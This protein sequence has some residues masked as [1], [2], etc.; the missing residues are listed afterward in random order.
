MIFDFLRSDNPTSTTRVSIFITT[1][2]FIPTFV[3][4]WAMVSLHWQQLQEVPQGV[5]WLMGV[6]LGSGVAKAGVEAV[7]NIFGKSETK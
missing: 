2:L 7:Q 3:V 1:I 4:V 5:V 6:L